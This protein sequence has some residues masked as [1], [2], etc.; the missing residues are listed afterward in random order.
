MHNG[1]LQVDKEK[2]SKSLGNLS[3]LSATLDEYGRD[4]VVMYFVKSHYRKP[5]EYSP[6]ALEQAQQSVER[7]RELGRRLDP[8]APPPSARRAEEFKYRFERALQADF[9]TPAALVQVFDFVS[10]LNRRADEGQAHSAGALRDMLW[11]L[12]LDNLLEP[13]DDAASDDVK[14]LVAEREQARTERD[15]AT[16]DERRDQLAALGWEV[17]DTPEGPRLVRK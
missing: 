10:Y 14:R 12:G 2:G 16:A 3:P 4:A 6:F 1:M 5:I 7:I 15:F 17:R 11:V 9:N 13:E 8:D